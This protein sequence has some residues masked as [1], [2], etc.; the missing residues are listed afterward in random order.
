MAG[1]RCPILRRREYSTLDSDAHC[2]SILVIDRAIDRD[3]V[4]LIAS[5]PIGTNAS[6]AFHLL[7]RHLNVAVPV[8]MCR[9][10]E[11]FCQSC[12]AQQP[13]DQGRHDVQPGHI[14]IQW[15]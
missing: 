10:T 4:V 8:A 1:S 13:L 12:E 14:C 5:I 11:G 2:N 15:W 9:Q 3:I 6:P 7:L